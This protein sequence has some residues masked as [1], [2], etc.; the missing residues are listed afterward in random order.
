MNKYFAILKSDVKNIQRDPILLILGFVPLLMLMICRYG[1]PFLAIYWLDVPNYYPLIIM[2]FTLMNAMFPAFIMT[3]ILLDEKDLGLL[4]VINST[5]LSISGVLLV[6]MFLIL[7]MGIF[8][9]FIIIAFNGH[10]Q[11]S[12]L[13]SL[14]F[15]LLSALAAPIITLLIASLAKNK[16]EGLTL[17]KVANLALFVPMGAVFMQSAWEFLFAVLPAFWVFHLLD[18]QFNFYFTAFVGIA[19]LLAMNYYV[20]RFAVRRLI[21]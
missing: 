16:V 2:F 21:S 10:V 4:P 12:F 15:S 1:F 19:V 3:F 8:S 11:W 6:R 17:L 7:V 18:A 5:P 20:F 14:M 9:S 13:E